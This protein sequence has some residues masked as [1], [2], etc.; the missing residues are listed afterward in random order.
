MPACPLVLHCLLPALC[1]A[2]LRVLQ[3]RQ[4]AACPYPFVC[5]VCTAA[6]CSQPMHPHCSKYSGRCIA[7]EASAQPIDPTN[8]LD[9]KQHKS[10]TAPTRRGTFPAPGHPHARS[11]FSACCLPS[12][13]LQATL[14]PA[15][16]SVPVACPPLCSRPPSCPLLLQ[17]LLPALPS[18]P[19]HP[20][21]PKPGRP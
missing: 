3:L 2:C 14:M 6:V 20:H 19:G 5:F 17:C 12:P 4:A 11:C 9:P 16:A 13:L 7:I 21:A 10:G 1:H 15:L 8:I 18:A